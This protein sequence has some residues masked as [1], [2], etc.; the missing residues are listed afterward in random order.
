MKKIF[1]IILMFIFVLTLSSCGKNE[2]IKILYTNDIHG[3]IAN[4]K[5]DENKNIIPLLRLNNLAAYKKKLIDEN[6]NVLLFDAGDE[7][8]GSVYGSLDKGVEMIKIL[9]KVGYDLAV[10]GNH[11]FDFGMDGFNRIVKDANYPFIS[12]NFRSLENNKNIFDS[13]KIFNIGGK[14]IG[15][16]GVSTPESITASTPSFF[17][18]DNGEFIYTFD[19]IKDR[20]DLYNSVQKAINEIRNDVDYLIILGHL[21]VGIDAEKAGIRSIDVINNTTGIDA[22]IDGH[23]HTVVENKIVKTK[24]NKDCILTQTGCYLDGIGEMT[25]NKDGIST[26]LINDLSS[27]SDNDVKI[28]EDSLIQSITNVLNNKIAKL[29]KPL[30]VTSSDNLKQRLVR[31]RE[32]N[33]GDFTSDSVYWYLNM[34]KELNCDIAL[35]NGGGIRANLLAGDITYLDAKTVEPYGNQVCLIKT[36]GK[37][38]KNALEMGV[39]VLEK[40]DAE[41]NTPA[42]NGGF[43]QVSGMKFEIDCSVKSSVKTDDHGMFLS[44]DGDYRVKNVMVYNKSTKVYENL[45]LNKEYYVGG[46]NYILRNS[47]NGLSMFK[48]SENVVDYVGEDYMILAN[49]MASFKS[50]NGDVVVNN[51]NSPLNKYENYLLDYENP[52]GS[53]RIK[54]LNL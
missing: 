31:A 54:I 12:C 39:T 4:Q 26:R 50:S 14:K 7:I 22:F 21:G 45:D 25:I 36:K 53:S 3:Y 40:W 42:E 32:T 24:D 17:Q 8:Q 44:V 28:M 47:G 30:L 46:I 27:Y 2:E 10:P 5:E 37:N 15:V 34:E 48:D 20:N 35:T 19:G 1:S 52:A 43:L 38:I 9:N 16:V 6:K 33:L 18:N 51:L 11:D 49:Y 13:S 23:S 29:E 41:W